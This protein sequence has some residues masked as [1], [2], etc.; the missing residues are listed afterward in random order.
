MW[1]M[2]KVPLQ[3]V[4]ERLPFLILDKLDIH[5]ALMKLSPYP[6]LMPS[7]NG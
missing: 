7:H 6:C 5:M 1:I 2:T 3:S 4:L